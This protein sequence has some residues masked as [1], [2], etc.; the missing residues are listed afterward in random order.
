MERVDSVR[1]ILRGRSLC[2]SSGSVG[3]NINDTPADLEADVEEEGPLLVG[4]R[5]SGGSSIVRLR[6]AG[7]GCDVGGGPPVS[8]DRRLA[9]FHRKRQRWDILSRHLSPLAHPS[10]VGS[11]C[12]KTSLQW[13]DSCP[14][15]GKQVVIMTRVGLKSFG[16]VVYTCVYL[17]DVAEA[18][19]LPSWSG[20]RGLLKNCEARVSRAVR[21]SDRACF[22]G[23]SDMKTFPACPAWSL[24]PDHGILGWDDGASGLLR[25]R[26]I[27]S[28]N[29]VVLR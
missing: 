24:R 17:L 18:V 3:F 20:T 10:N 22:P 14:W 1:A 29:T 16:K 27:G 12:M 13:Q 21:L 8:E 25:R 11:H 19:L 26:R 4:A 5:D 2:G 6:P 15:R 23:C 7:G 9:S 28:S